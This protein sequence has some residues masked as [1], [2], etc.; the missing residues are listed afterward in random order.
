MGNLEIVW[1]R[2]PHCLNPLFSLYSVCV[3]RQVLNLSEPWFLCLS[4]VE[5]IM[6]T[7]EQT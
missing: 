5:R 6:P 4:S 2:E 3:S 7:C 1:V